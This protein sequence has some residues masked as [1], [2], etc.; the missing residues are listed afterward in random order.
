MRERDPPDGIVGEHLLRLPVAECGEIAAGAKIDDEP[1]DLVS[2]DEPTELGKK[3][4]AEATQDLPLE[5]DPPV[6][7]LLP[8]GLPLQR[9]P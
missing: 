2:R 3:R 6:R 1:E 5:P 7:L 9:R 8:E 4:V